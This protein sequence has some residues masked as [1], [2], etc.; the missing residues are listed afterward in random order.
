MPSACSFSTFI[1]IIIGLSGKNN[2]DFEALDW[3]DMEARD[4][5]LSILKKAEKYKSSARYEKM[6]D[7]V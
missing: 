4:E 6:E 7:S 1:T 5:I 2:R 3:V